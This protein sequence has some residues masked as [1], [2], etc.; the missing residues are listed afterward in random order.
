VM[1]YQFKSPVRM[2]G[3][4][5]HDFSVAR[6]P[7]VSVE[8]TEHHVFFRRDNEQA[9]TVEE[10]RVPWSNIA[11]TMITRTLKVA[12][13]VPPKVP[14]PAKRLTDAAIERMGRDR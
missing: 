14:A 10:M 11:L 6:F 2:F 7:N 1:V 9:G 4:E 5:R 13:V 8:E 12:E 3:S